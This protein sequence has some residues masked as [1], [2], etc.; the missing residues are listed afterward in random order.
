MSRA[1]TPWGA[2]LALQAIGWGAALFSAG[3]VWAAI[4]G[5]QIWE[6]GADQALTTG[7]V[8]GYAAMLALAAAVLVWRGRRLSRRHLDGR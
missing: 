3:F 6:D 2:G 8:L 4:T 7:E 1:S 5:Q